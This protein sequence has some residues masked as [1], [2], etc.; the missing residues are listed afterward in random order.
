MLGLPACPLFRGLWMILA[1]R[2]LRLVVSGRLGTVLRGFSRTLPNLA[3]SK[4]CMLWFF[5]FSLEIMHFISLGFGFG[6][7]TCWFF[8]YLRISCSVF[9][10][11]KMK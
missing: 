4:C 11:I 2:S 8:I 3:P 10:R 6:Y 9:F 1:T 5:F 7:H